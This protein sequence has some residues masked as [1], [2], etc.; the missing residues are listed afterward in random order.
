MLINKDRLNNKL[1]LNMFFQNACV[2]YCLLTLVSL[3]LAL[4]CSTVSIAQDNDGHKLD[5]IKTHFRN[6]GN[7]AEKIKLSFAIVEEFMD[8]D[9]YDSAQIWLNKIAEIIPVRQA[10]P[11]AYFLSSRQAEIYYYNRLLQLGLQESKRSLNIAKALHDSLLMADAYNFAGLFYMNLDSPE[12]AIPNFINGIKFI[13]QPPYASQYPELTKP[14]HLY[15]NL[16]EAYEKTGQY[17]TS[18][19]YATKSLQLA[20]EINSVRGISMAL[21]NIGIDYLKLNLPDSANSYFNLSIVSS[22]KGKDF[23]IELLNYGSLGQ[24]HELKQNKSEALRALDSG[25]DLIRNNPSVNN[26]F[27]ILFLDDAISVYKNYKLESR[28]IDVLQ[29]KND[30]LQNQMKR[31]TKQMSIILDASLQNETRVLG[32]QVEQAKQQNKKSKV[33]LYYLSA[34]IF[35][36]IIAFVFYRYAITQKLQKSTLSNKISKDLHDDVGSSLSSLNLYSTV[37]T[38]VFDSNPGKA[39]EML[40]KISDQSLLI[41][42]NISDIVWSMKATTDETVNLTTKIKILVA[43]T[44]SAAEINYK[45]NIDPSEEITVKSI[46]AKRT[47]LMI[48]KEAINNSVKYSSA[49]NITITLK[50]INNALFVEIKDDGK[51]FDPAVNKA[52]TNG[53]VNMQKRAIELQGSVDIKSGPGAGTT[54]TALLPLAALNNLG[55]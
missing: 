31:N 47:I 54:V 44:L 24:A 3:M 32:L 10:S 4:L 1:H 21:N 5:S 55:W 19:F 13:R 49:T 6:S 39:K 52:H 17:D 16:A 26:L 38:K 28:L 7:E 51:G 46:A 45:I 14:H 27:T 8:M 18:I 22:R 11:S 42:E 15:S 30:L 9:Q 50:K 23:D 34:L 2:K 53:L 33:T 29:Q 37:A 35:L 25:F 20:Q 43:D 12:I 48:I 40:Q 36:G 41:M